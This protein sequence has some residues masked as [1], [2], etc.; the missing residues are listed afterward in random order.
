MV[1]GVCGQERRSFDV[2]LIEMKTSPQNNRFVVNWLLIGVV[3]VFV[4][5]VLG[6]ITRLTGSGLSITRW[7]IVVGSIPP[8]NGQQWS[9]AFEL[10]KQTPQYQK[11]NLG[12]SLSDFK[13]IFFWE[14]IH[15]LWARSIGLV[16][17]I[18]FVI[19]LVK[20][21][22]NKP[23]MR[24]LLVVIGIA[25]LAA[26][27]GWIMVA[28]GLKDRPWVNAYN[29]TIHLTIGTALLIYLIYT[30]QKEKGHE[31][32][33]VNKS[34]RNWIW[35]LLVVGVI[36]FWFGGFVS[37]MRA[38]LSY[39]TWPDM[40]GKWIPDILLD[41]SHWNLD[42]LLMYDKSGFMSAL[43]QFIHRH[44]AYLLLILVSVFV[45]KWIKERQ[46]Q[47]HWI[48]WLLLGLI[49]VQA[50]LGIL[51]LVGS[52]GSIPIALGSLHQIGGVL[53]VSYLFYILLIFKRQRF[54]Y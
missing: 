34:W 3:L 45:Y 12:M 41:T 30:W 1:V 20:G 38:A 9:D 5:I 15:R 6:G 19:F 31:I 37:G 10:Y 16:F 17:V 26:S 35:L 49:L 33:L 13:F 22:I 28:S 36:Q 14:F 40:H 8:L 25:L 32:I 27:F 4:Q 52:K 43:V 46:G 29:L 48:G 44:V 2:S 39:P 7:D 51:T 54:V 18:P 11:I 23:L 50:L 21:W 24:R 42:S 47:E 53:L